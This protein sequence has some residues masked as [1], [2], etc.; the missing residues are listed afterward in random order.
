MDTYTNIPKLHGMENITN[1]E[2]IYKLDM[3]QARYGK[4]DEFGWW[5]M[6]R[7]QTDAGMQF[8]SREFQKG[9]YVRG[10]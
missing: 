5:D 1:E 6:E 9:L 7:I 8:N 4:V 10:V 3:F 2:V